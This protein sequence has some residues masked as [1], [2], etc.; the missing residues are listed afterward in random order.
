MSGLSSEYCRGNR[1]INGYCRMVQEPFLITAT[2]EVQKSSRF[3]KVP[4]QNR[5][6]VLNFDE[7]VH[8]YPVHF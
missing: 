6:L 8:G 4:Y 5:N 7:E 1:W 3:Q 2:V